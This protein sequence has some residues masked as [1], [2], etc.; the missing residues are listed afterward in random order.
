MKTI[1]KED[2]CRNLFKNLVEDYPKSIPELIEVL[3]ELYDKYE[4]QQLEDEEDTELED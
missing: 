3:S 1:D 2:I 4:L